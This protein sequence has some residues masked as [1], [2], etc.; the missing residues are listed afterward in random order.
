[1]NIKILTAPGPV[2]FPL[3]ATDSEGLEIKFGKDGNSDVILDSSISLIKRRLPIHMVLLSGLSIVSPDFMG[4][5]AVMRKGGASDTLSRII[6]RNE[7]LPVNFVYGENMQEIKNLLNS[8]KASSAVVMSMSGMDGITL[9][10]RALKAGIYVP[11]S[12]AASFEDKSIMNEFKNIYTEGF[13]KLRE[14]PQE[15]AE[16]V[17]KK[18]PSRFPVEFISGT[19]NST[20][21][22]MEKPENYN[23]LEEAVLNA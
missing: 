23:K 8:G 13:K 11:G 7:H 3:L 10:E 17:S 18:L 19:M 14:N 9:E 4:T 20:T 22:I 1:M 2:C 21:Q 15:F 12:C 5:T 6:V 16:T